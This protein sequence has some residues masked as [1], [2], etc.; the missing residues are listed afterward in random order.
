MVNL[1]DISGWM[2][3]DSL[4]TRFPETINLSVNVSVFTTKAS[5]FG[6]GGFWP[7]AFGFSI[8]LFLQAE[9][10]KLALKMMALTR[11]IVDILRDLKINVQTAKV[12]LSWT[13]GC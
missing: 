7:A 6:T 9:R 13:G 8:C 10:I 12:V 2:L 11:K 1:P 3:V 4:A 5:T